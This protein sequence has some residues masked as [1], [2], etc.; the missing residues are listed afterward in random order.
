[1]NLHVD[2][3]GNLGLFWILSESRYETDIIKEVK[4]RKS[5]KK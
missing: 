4:I 2:S 1:M 5:V 3:S